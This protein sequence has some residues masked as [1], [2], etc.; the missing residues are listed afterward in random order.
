MMETDE[1]RNQKMTP[2]LF[3]TTNLTS[4]SMRLHYE[5]GR[6]TRT[7]LGALV[8]GL[9]KGVAELHLKMSPDSVKIVQEKFRLKGADH[10]IF[11]V[12]WKVPLSLLLSLSLPFSP[13]PSSHHITSH[14]IIRSET[15]EMKRNTERRREWK[16]VSKSCL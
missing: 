14:H 4:S 5:P 2:P 10:D 15:D 6:P 13:F 7:G 11:L 8:I 3:R 1:R 12:S 16:D 9:V